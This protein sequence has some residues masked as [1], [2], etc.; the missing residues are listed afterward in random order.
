[1][2][3]WVQFFKF[4]SQQFQFLGF[5]FIEF[6]NLWAQFK[7]SFN[8]VYTLHTPQSYSSKDMNKKLKL[9]YQSPTLKLYFT[10]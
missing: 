9:E 1:M 4:L 5:F 2:Q 6:K 7:K 10:C 3:V 8:S